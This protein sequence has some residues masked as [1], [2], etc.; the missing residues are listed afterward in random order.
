MRRISA[1]AGQQ[2][3]Q[4]GSDGE[5]RIS[6]VDAIGEVSAADWDACANPDRFAMMPNAMTGVCS[7]RC[8]PEKRR[9][10]RPAKS[11]Q[12]YGL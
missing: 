8:E 4:R 10:S 1:I 5:L 12:E 9:G 7:I 3:Q 6:V 2:R 11:D